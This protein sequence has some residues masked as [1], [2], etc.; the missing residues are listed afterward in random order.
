MRCYL[1]RQGRI[2][3]V[4][5][6]TSNTDRALAEE[7]EEIFAARSKNLGWDGFE[8]WDGLRFV[9]RHPPDVDQPKEKKNKRV[10]RDANTF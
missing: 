6:L 1:M 9:Y 2:A 7:A 4:E 3:A 10:R 8:V 5:L